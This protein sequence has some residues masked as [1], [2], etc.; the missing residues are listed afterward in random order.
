MRAR[1][2]IRRGRPCAPKTPSTERS[3]LLLL[4]FCISLYCLVYI[5]I[6]PFVRSA[7]ISRILRA[8]R[9][10]SCYNATFASCIRYAHVRWRMLLSDSLAKLLEIRMIYKKKYAV[11]VASLTGAWDAA[12]HD[13]L[14]CWSSCAR[15]AL[16]PDDAKIV[17]ELNKQAF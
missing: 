17:M 11:V 6:K 2:H 3:V 4:L 14:L 1:S 10:A 15:F 12:R 8:Q 7:I 16:R 5:Y 9:D 13:R